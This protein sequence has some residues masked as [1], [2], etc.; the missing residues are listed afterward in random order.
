MTAAE[1]S[2]E[3]A[4]RFLVT[5]VHTT[6][7][8]SPTDSAYAE[9]AAPSKATSTAPRRSSGK[10]YGRVGPDLLRCGFLAAD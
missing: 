6:R 2:R 7:T 8:P 4:L 5:G 3:P 9:A 1:A 10:R